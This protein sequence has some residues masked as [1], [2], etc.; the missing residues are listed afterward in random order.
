M[1][2]LEVIAGRRSVREYRPDQPPQDAIERIIAAAVLAPSAVNRQPWSF[3]VVRNSALLDEISRQAKAHM[4]RNRPLP[5]PESLYEKLGDADFHVFY[6]APVLIV[7]SGPAGEPWM[8]EDCAMAAQN[9]ML[10]A[11]D[12]GM[13][14]CW[15]GLAQPW[16]A[17]PEGKKAVGLPQ[18]RA[19]LAPIILGYPSAAA[20]SVPRKSPH[21][22][23]IDD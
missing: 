2:L 23:W 17:T 10:A 11:H 12:L 1:E 22:R 4:T 8:A 21:I 18:D 3:T 16:L 9:M 5:L 13:G 20:P 7:I 19:P 15:I 14:S 6:R